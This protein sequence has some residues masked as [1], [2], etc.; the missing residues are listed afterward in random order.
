MPGKR[1][2]PKSKNARRRNG[3]LQPPIGNPPGAEMSAYSSKDIRRLVDLPAEFV[4]SLARAGHIH[5]ERINNKVSYSFQDLLVLRT[6]SALHAAKIPP[7]KITDALSKIRDALPPGSGLNVLS[8]A[9]AGKD[10]VVREG[11]R[12][13]EST[14]G[15]YALPLTIDA[16]A[17]SVSTLK[18]K[19]AVDRRRVD[20]E[21]HFAS[22]LELEDSDIVAARA[23]YLAALDAHGEHLE[24]RINLGRL[25]HLNG[26]LDQAEKIYRE[27][28]H[29]SGLLSFNLAIVLEDLNREEEAILA[30]REALAL[31][32]TLH[33]AHFNLSRLHERADRPREALR[34]LLA[35]RRH[36]REQGD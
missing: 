31:E 9:P 29:A 5:P 36:T 30:Y 14:T 23:A 22:A 25:L 27:A 15:Q 19:A 17:S 1:S 8:L 28:K 3:R 2:T 16:R 34:H 10:V 32:P 6:A 4:K 26:E 7:R 12:L 11:T 18:R 24:A 21:Q 20:A 13:W 35:Y 33:D